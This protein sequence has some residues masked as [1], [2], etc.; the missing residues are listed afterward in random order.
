MIKKM[1]KSQIL[2]EADEK[3]CAVKKPYAARTA[4][5]RTRGPKKKLQKELG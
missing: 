4:K 5:Q 3:C 1:A 2:A